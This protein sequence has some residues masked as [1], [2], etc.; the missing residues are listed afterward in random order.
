MDPERLDRRPAWADGDVGLIGLGHMGEPMAVRLLDAGRRL[1]VWNRTRPA[2]ERLQARGAYVAASAQE[3]VDRCRVVV[4]ALA[5]RAAFEDVFGGVDAQTPLVVRDRVVVNVGTISPA[6]S[7]ALHDLIVARGATYIEAPVSGST[8]QV[9]AGSLVG[10]LA[11][12]EATCAAVQKLVAPLC[13]SVLFCG[14]VPHALAL[15]LAV[16]SYLIT[17]V[18]GLAET[19][20]FAEQTGVDLGLLSESLGVGPMSSEVMRIK[21]DKLVRDDHSPQATIRDVRY[22]ADLVLDSASEKGIELPLLRAAWHLLGSAQDL[23]ESANDMVAVIAALRT[24]RGA[25]Q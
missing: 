19:V 10:M 14:E 18:V 5:H 22:N 3:V 6:D 25:S 21:L 24:R 13:R 7:S 12:D 2:A 17:M 4:V 16:N 20:H 23:G 11:G 8:A 1:V 15:K 9:A